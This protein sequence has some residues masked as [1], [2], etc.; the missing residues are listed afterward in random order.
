MRTLIPICILLAQFFASSVRAQTYDVQETATLRWCPPMSETVRSYIVPASYTATGVVTTVSEPVV[1]ERRVLPPRPP[2]ELFAPLLSTGE[3]LT[4]LLP[5]SSLRSPDLQLAGTPDSVEKKNPFQG[6]MEPKDLP[7]DAVIQ[8]SQTLT[9]VSKPQQMPMEIKDA[10]TDA[11][12]VRTPP[13]AAVTLGQSA[14]RNPLDEA[15]SEPLPPPGGLVDMSEIDPKLL[16]SDPVVT[17]SPPDR[18]DLSD[19]KIAANVPAVSGNAHWVSGALLLTTIIATMVAC[20]AVIL[21]FEFRSRWM[22]T[23]TEQNS[24]FSLGFED[25]YELGTDY[26]RS[27]FYSDVPGLS[28]FGA[29]MLETSTRRF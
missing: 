7:K 12:E 13:V 15:I 10:T 4:P 3:N 16:E 20:Y 27:T 23:V 9:T 1:I 29:D 26:G 17:P 11:E 21:A 14:P 8:T 2:E 5:A 18:T 22:Q 25:D 28:G 24:R 6:I 19:D